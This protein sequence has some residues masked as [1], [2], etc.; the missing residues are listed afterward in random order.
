MSDIRKSIDIIENVS[1]NEDVADTFRKKIKHPEMNHEL[2]DLI[3]GKIDSRNFEGSF[4]DKSK[5]TRLIKKLGFT[6][7]DKELFQCYIVQNIGIP[8][9]RYFHIHIKEGDKFTLNVETV[10]VY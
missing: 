4:E 6:K 3:T 5:F 1:L 7:I 8:T 2:S 10:E 9:I